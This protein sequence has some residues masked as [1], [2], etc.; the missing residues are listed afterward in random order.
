M[1]HYAEAPEDE[2]ELSIINKLFNFSE[3]SRPDAEARLYLDEKVPPLITAIE[4]SWL[5]SMLMDDAF[6]YL[7][8]AELRNKLLLLLVD[9]SPLYTPEMWQGR[10]G[11][12][13]TPATLL[14][15]LLDALENHL[16]LL[17]GNHELLIP[18]RL[19]YDLATGKY[20]LIAWQPSGQ[21]IIRLPLDNALSLK[22]ATAPSSHHFAEAASYIS[23]HKK[24][25]TLRIK[26]TRNAIERCFLLFGT[27]DKTARI[28]SADTYWLVVAYYDFEEE[29]LL[30]KIM[31]LHSSATVKGPENIRKAIIQRISET[32]RIYL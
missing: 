23:S 3:D 5:K 1:F 24:E 4:M 7:L 21:K 15:D 13:A 16:P 28:E 31:S 32:A 25:V 9:I 2:R 26:P 20:A 19:E 30:Q 22:K 8:P 27:Y 18:Y 17:H 29:E 11:A 6:S 10:P 12:D 14:P